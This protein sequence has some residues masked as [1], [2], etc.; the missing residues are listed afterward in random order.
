MK[1]LKIIIFIMD[2]IG[3]AKRVAL[4]SKSYPTAKEIILQSLKSMGQFLQA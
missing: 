4:L 2:I 3:L 1:K